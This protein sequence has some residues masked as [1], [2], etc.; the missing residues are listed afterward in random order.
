MECSL[1]GYD[2]FLVLDHKDGGGS[3]HRKEIQQRGNSMVGWIIANDFPDLFRV[4]CWNCNQAL[5]FYGYCPHHATV[6]A[7]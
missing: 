2:P 3:A 7:T 6:V 4:L 1:C 5:G